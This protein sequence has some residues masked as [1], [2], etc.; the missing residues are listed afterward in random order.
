MRE[1]LYKLFE[2]QILSREEAKTILTNIAKGVYND[3]QIAALISVYLMRSITLE[4]LAGFRDALLEMC[5][6]L[7]FSDFDP[8]DIVGTGGD[9]KNTF[10]V[11]TA[12]CFVVAGAGHKV[13]KH[14]SYGSSS[15]SGAS[16]VME[17]HGVKFTTNANQLRRSLEKTNIAYLHAPLFNA[18][19]KTVA[20]VR[21]ALA[22]RTFFN[23]LGPLVNPARPRRNLLGVFNLP[24]AR[25]YAYM[26]Q[27]EKCD[28]AV[29]HSLDGYDEIS[30]TADFKVID[31]S[32]EQVYTPKRL[33]FDRLD[34]IQLHG[35]E[36]PQEAA[37][38]FSNVM[39]N[40]A[41]K[42]QTDVVIVNAAFAIKTIEPGTEL[43]DCCAQARESVESGRAKEAL[44]K[45]VDLNS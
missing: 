23:V 29:V 5:I 44:C 13:V 2:H 43:A 3:S 22:V 36:S 31:K 15:I 41:T 37:V 42:A 6:P 30:L 19:L 32:G 39:N 21:K 12:A 27:R 10:N 16:N 14:G 11:S 45:Y 9:N 25:L 24:M 18:A 28:F 33:G 20:P 4:E 34:Q 35:G 40:K 26:Y 38:I 7:D 8:I 1:I 17:Q